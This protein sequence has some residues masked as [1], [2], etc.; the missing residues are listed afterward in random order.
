MSAGIKNRNRDKYERIRKMMWIKC[1]ACGRL[2][3]YKDYRNNHYVCPRCG[4]AFIMTP[5]QRFNLLFDTIYWDTYNLPVST[6]D[7]L[8]FVDRITY[9]DRLSEAREETGY[10]DAV[11][12]ADGKIDSI[13]TTVCVMNGDFM[14]GSMGRAAGDAI[15]ASIEHAI[16][17]KNPFVMVTCSGGARMQENI[18]SLMQQIY[19]RRLSK[20]L[21]IIC[22]YNL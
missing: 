15:V 3:Y 21:K 20:K 13:N 9:Q 5:K 17:L 7:P 22:N 19:Q 4:R 14:M 10:N 1:E 8:K 11:A 18:L 2:V 16:E 12:T 6:D